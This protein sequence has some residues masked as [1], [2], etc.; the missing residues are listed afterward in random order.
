SAS[1]HPWRNRLECPAAAA[2]SPPLRF[3][4]A[5]DA[6]RRP[7][8]RLE[9]LLRNLP[10]ASRA[11]AVGAVVEPLQRRIDRGEHSRRVLLERVVDLA[12]ERDRR[13]LREVV[14]LRRRDLLDLVVQPA[15]M[16]LA[17]VRDRAFDPLALVEQKRAKTI[18]VDAHERL[19]FLPRYD[20][21]ADASRRSIKAGP[22]PV[23]S[24][25]LSRAPCPE[26][27]STA[28]SGSARVS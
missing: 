7:W 13:R 24:M 14:V 25:I 23:S 19:S 9:P 4:F 2:R 28:L 11:R 5:V 27:I 6:Q 20:D 1:A 22:T 18:G 16:V 3:P 8:I 12:I 15:G 10:V 26:T 21:D 17:Q